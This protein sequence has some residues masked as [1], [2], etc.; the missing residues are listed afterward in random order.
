M[1]I[2]NKISQKMDFVNCEI[3]IDENGEIMIIEYDKEGAVIDEYNLKEELE[4]QEG[5]LNE[6]GFKLTIARSVSRD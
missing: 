1:K 4:R 3:V 6:V 5:F 2:E